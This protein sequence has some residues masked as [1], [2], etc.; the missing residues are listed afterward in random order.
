MTA[1]T[2]R[3]VIRL[4]TRGS[5]LALIQTRLIASLLETRDPDIE[6][7]ERVIATRG[8]HDRT[9]PLPAIGGKGVFTEELERALR[10][11]DIDVAVHS[12]KDLPV[13]PAADL[14]LGAIPLRADARDALVS[15]H[16]SIEALPEGAVVGTSSVR[17]AAQLR[18][19]RPDLEV[20]AL[21]G[22]V[23]T[24]VARVRE[25][26]LE[27]A[28]L[29]AAGLHRLGLDAE[30]AELLPID[31]FLP[32]PGQGALAVQCRADDT[33]VL[34]ALASIDDARIRAATTA[35][36]AFL[37][38]LGGGCS[39]PISALAETSDGGTGLH[40]RGQVSARDGSRVVNVAAAGGLDE[41]A[42]V[43]HRLAGEALRLGAAE[44]LA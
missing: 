30:I 6:T 26:A 3:R 36:R 44:L 4:G 37:A 23:E 11:G 41:A 2:P 39:M 22:N 19:L 43:G 35:E 31:V 38:A 40:L 25:G 10:T 13:E 34:A 33:V 17:R 16:R 18:S 14:V 32:A 5:G 27:A 9:S 21:R 15:R 7:V 20:R 28:I 42:A 8:D 12:L 24:R 1:G 29:A